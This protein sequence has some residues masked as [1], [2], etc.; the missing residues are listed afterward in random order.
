MPIRL[1]CESAQQ[2]KAAFS[3]LF[4]ANNLSNALM[5]VVDFEAKT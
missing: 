5:V 3:C 4:F 2:K 1:I